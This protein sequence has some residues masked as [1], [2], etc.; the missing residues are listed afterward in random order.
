MLLQEQRHN[1]VA[2]WAYRQQNEIK[3]WNIPNSSN[4]WVP[5]Q[6]NFILLKSQARVTDNVRI[7]DK[8]YRSEW[9]F[10]STDKIELVRG[11]HFLQ[12]QSMNP[13]LTALKK[14]I[15]WF[16]RHDKNY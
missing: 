2:H 16:N 7:A 8:S 11:W 14:K 10:W 15:G 6:N 3:K 9:R 5:P 4:R 1:L 13:F 12:R